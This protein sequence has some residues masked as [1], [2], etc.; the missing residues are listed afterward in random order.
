MNDAHADSDAAAVHHRDGNAA[1][2]ADSDTAAV[3]CRNGSAAVH[4]E[5]DAAA[6]NAPHDHI[7]VDSHLACTVVLAPEGHH[8][9]GTV[10]LHVENTAVTVTVT[11]VSLLAYPH[12]VNADGCPKTKLA[13]SEMTPDHVGTRDHLTGSDLDPVA[14][15]VACMNAWTESEWAQVVGAVQQQANHFG[16]SG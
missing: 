7:A 9:R 5:P 6:V 15:R 4:P 13:C 8:R 11:A 14:D 2:H 16:Q 12:P 3:H 10:G 1:G